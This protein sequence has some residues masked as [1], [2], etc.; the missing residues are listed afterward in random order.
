MVVEVQN[1]SVPHEAKFVKKTAHAANHL[2]PESR[3]A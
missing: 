1:L 2:E 3:Y